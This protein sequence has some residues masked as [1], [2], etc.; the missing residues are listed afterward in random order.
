MMRTVVAGVASMLAVG[1]AMATQSGVGVGAKPVGPITIPQNDRSFDPQNLRQLAPS[2]ER[3]QAQVERLDRELDKARAELA[4]TRGELATTRT[5]MAA[6]RTELDGF[7]QLA[8]LAADKVN[9]LDVRHRDHQHPYSYKGVN[10]TTKWF[11]TSGRPIV[12]DE[13][14]DYATVITGTPSYEGRTGAPVP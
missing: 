13:K 3:T 8:R 1:A 2:L 10:F 6:M 12:K 9:A 5:E 4:M 14:T 7:K 11:V